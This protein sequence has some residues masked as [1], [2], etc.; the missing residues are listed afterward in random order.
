MESLRRK[1]EGGRRKVLALLLLPSFSFLLAQD[2]RPLP[3]FDTLYNTVR[4]NLAK[5]ERVAYLYAFKERRTDVHTN[6]FGRIGTGGTRVFEVYPSANPQLTYRRLIERNGIPV[7]ARQLA[8]QDREY[9]ARV[10]DMQRRQTERADAE[11]RR[12]E[13][14]AASARR[15]GQT[16]IDDV[17]DALQFK[18]DG[19]AVH[20]GVPTIVVSF[21]PRPGARPATREGRIA[22]KFAGTVWI[23][24]TAF[25]VM[26]VDAK[27]IDDLSFGLGVV[28]R[29]NEGTTATLVRRPVDGDVWMP[30]EL[31]L[32]GRGRAALVRRLVMD[33][34]VQWFD[35][36]RLPG[37]SPAPFLDPRVESQAGRGPQ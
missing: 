31:E 6:P 7:L 33:F 16:M 3:D 21:S 34:S 25:E 29:L 10:A 12:R 1:K 30:T 4:K 32:S 28:A 14:D 13:E 15:R 2:S 20:N 23:H 24:E 11:R 17:V 19:R 5:S 8:E 35:Y 36:R 26:R 22:Q 27:A 18:L 37:D 9:K